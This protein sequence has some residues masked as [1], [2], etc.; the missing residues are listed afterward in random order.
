MLF[1]DE[2]CSGINLMRDTGIPIARCGSYCNHSAVL[3]RQDGS[4]LVELVRF[5]NA[6]GLSVW[7]DDL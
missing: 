5:L 2:P 4:W 6:I 7:I 1:L 3:L